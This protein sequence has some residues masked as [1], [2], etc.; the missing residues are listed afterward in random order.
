MDEN[1]PQEAQRFAVYDETL[2]QYVGPTH[3][4]ESAAKDA[5]TEARKLS[6]H[7]GHKLAVRPV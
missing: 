2:T 1:T 7:K 4:S 6:R 5:A 3:G